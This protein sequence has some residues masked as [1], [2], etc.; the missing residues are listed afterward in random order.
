MKG[1]VE[2]GFSIGVT[3]SLDRFSEPNL[4]QTIIKIVNIIFFNLNDLA[5]KNTPNLLVL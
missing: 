3:G 4:I 1:E 5:K 2:H